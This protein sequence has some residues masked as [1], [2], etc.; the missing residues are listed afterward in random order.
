MEVMPL[1]ECEEKPV[2]DGKPGTTTLKILSEYRKI[3][4]P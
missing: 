3:I 1:V 2:G 4:S